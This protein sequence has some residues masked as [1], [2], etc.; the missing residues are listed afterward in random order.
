[1]VGA[2]TSLPSL[3]QV[4]KPHKKIQLTKQLDGVSVPPEASNNRAEA[5]TIQAFPRLESVTNFDV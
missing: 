4:N 1:M 3:I 5:R 2:L